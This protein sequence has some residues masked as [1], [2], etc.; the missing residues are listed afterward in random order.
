MGLV[1]D[2]ADPESVICRLSVSDPAAGRLFAFGPVSPRPRSP[3]CVNR[4]RT[5]RVERRRPACPGFPLAAPK[6][7]VGVTVW[8]DL[9]GWG[10]CGLV[11][12]ALAEAIS[13]GGVVGFVEGGLAQ[14]PRASQR[15]HRGHYRRELCDSA[16]RLGASGE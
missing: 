16:N 15:S 10:V 11:I 1:N 5:T 2:L 12:G 9:V 13:G 4:E 14:A 7:G 8:T 6:L 3:V